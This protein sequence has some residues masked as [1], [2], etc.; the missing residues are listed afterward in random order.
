MIRENPMEEKHR[1]VEEDA[2]KIWDWIKTRGGLAVWRSINLSNAGASWTTP[3][4]DDKGNKVE[5]PTWQ[6]AQSPTRTITSADDVEVSV[7]KEVKR[8]RVGIRIGAQGLSLKVTDGGYRRIK[9]AVEKAYD[10][11]EKSA[12]YV[13]DYST[14]EAVIFIDDKVIPL[15]DYARDRGWE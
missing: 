13:F 2:R 4:N 9:A 12:W 10:T 11:H 7:P 5:K 1:V 8:F 15:T 6:A 3:V 14:Q